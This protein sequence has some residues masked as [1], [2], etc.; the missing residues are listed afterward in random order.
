MVQTADGGVHVLSRSAGGCVSTGMTEC[1]RNYF[2]TSGVCLQV[3]DCI[4]NAWDLLSVF[5]FLVKM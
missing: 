4:G 1:A 2:L 5:F 3:R